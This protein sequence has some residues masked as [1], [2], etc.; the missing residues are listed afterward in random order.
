MHSHLDALQVMAPV[1]LRRGPSEVHSVAKRASFYIAFGRNFYG[2]R[3]DFGR[4]G[5]GKMEGKIDFWE[6]FRRCFFAM[7]FGIDLGWIF[8]GSKAEKSIKTISFSMFFAHFQKIDIFEKSMKK[9]R[10]W[11]RFRRPKWRKFE[12][13]MELKNMWFFNF[14]VFIFFRFF[15]ILAR[16]WE[17]PGPPKIEKNQKKSIFSRVPF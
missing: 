11:L 7:R 17:A 16:F 15:T 2:F 3:I 8:G 10:F 1:A 9:P 12:K 5:G 6:V 13:K 14:D 4:F